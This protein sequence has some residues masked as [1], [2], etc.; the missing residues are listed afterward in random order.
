MINTDTA[1]TTLSDLVNKHENLISE[2]AETD[3]VI[4]CATEFRS[5]INNASEKEKGLAIEKLTKLTRSSS[6][7]AYE[8]MLQELMRS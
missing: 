8:L 3:L 6:N 2:K 5:R 1:T 4:Q 7:K